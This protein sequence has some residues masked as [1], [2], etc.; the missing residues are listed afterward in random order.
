[1]RY[2]IKV[3][4]WSVRGISSVKFTDRCLACTVLQLD[5]WGCI[6]GRSCLAVFPY[7]K[8]IF[9][10][11]IKKKRRERKPKALLACF[12]LCTHQYVVYVPTPLRKLQEPAVV[13][14]GQFL[15]N[16]NP[17]FLPTSRDVKRQMKYHC[18]LKFLE[19]R[20]KN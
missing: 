1:M 5:A 13:S 20:N 14:R 18:T 7:T 19:I 8:H 6:L 9:I 12:M 4:H 16:S 10:H 11:H 15:W 3:L 2:E 17:P